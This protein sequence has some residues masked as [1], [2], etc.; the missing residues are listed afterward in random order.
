MDRLAE[1]VRE[2][3][4]LVLTDQPPPPHLEPL[5]H[6]LNGSVSGAPA[7]NALNGASATIPSFDGA[8][9]LTSAGHAAPGE[10]GSMEILI[11]EGPYLYPIGSSAAGWGSV[12]SAARTARVL[13]IARAA[14][15]ACRLLGEAEVRTDPIRPQVNARLFARAAAVL[16]GK[17]ASVRQRPPAPLDGMELRLPSVG[18]WA[19]SLQLSRR[20]SKALARRVIPWRR[21]RQEQWTIGFVPADAVDPGKGFPWRRVGWIEPP[22]GGFIAD[23]FLVEDQGQYWLFYEHLGFDEGKGTLWVAP[24][25]RDAP[26]LEKGRKVLETAFHLSFPNVFR[27]G[28]QWYMLPE[29]SRSGKTTLYR[30]ST[31]PYEW[32]PFH[33][34]LPDFPGTDPV[35]F[36]HEGRWWLFVTQGAHPCNENNLHVFWSDELEGRFQAHPMNPVRTGLRGSRMA[37]P[38]RELDGRL[39]RPGQDCREGYGQGV[40]LF[41]ITELTPHSYA[42]RDWCSWPPSRQE[43]FGDAFHTYMVCDDILMVDGRRDQSG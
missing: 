35:L 32:R 30:A 7:G 10:G 18:V 26:D 42:E 36:N 24:F 28:N 23:P 40:V 16:V 6:E 33:D 11:E 12:V 17:A 2:N 5:L 38:V 15:G 3:S 9:D 4:M 39:I 27:D 14:D 19:K 1:A 25:D 20:V 29:Q 13:L 43:P 41:E 34:V 22:D 21:H 37:G 8:L 31:F